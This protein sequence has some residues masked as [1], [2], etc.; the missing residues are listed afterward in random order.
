MDKK[1][2][3]TIMEELHEGYRLQRKI[4]NAVRQYNSITHNDLLE[5]Y[6]MV[7]THEFTVQELLEE[8]MDDRNGDIDWW[9][10]EIE[11]GENYTPGDVVVDGNEIELRTAEQLYDFLVWQKEER[12]NNENKDKN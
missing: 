11:Y 9:C 3:C 2:F 10:N 6:G 8:V 7:C 4:A 1:Q 12:I 5:P